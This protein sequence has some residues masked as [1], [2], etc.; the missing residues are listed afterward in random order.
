MITY[1][2]DFRHFVV[3]VEA[4]EPQRAEFVWQL[5]QLCVFHLSTLQFVHEQSMK[6]ER[7]RVA[8]E[9]SHFV[10]RALLHKFLHFLKTQNA[11]QL[12]GDLKLLFDFLTYPL[13]GDLLSQHVFLVSRFQRGLHLVRIRYSFQ[14]VSLRL[15]QCLQIVRDVTLHGLSTLNLLAFD[16][17][18][19]SL[20]RFHQETLVTPFDCMLNRDVV[21]SNLFV[22]V[23]WDDC[24]KLVIENQSVEIRLLC[25]VKTRV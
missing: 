2:A 24:R 15:R 12:Q 7:S 6:Q 17:S 25:K 19:A 20:P 22:V 14:E 18:N 23:P 13:F 8:D 16:K 11:V 3:N 1:V 9:S 4:D 10:L 21:F 5:L